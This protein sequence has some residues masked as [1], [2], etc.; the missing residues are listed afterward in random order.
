M[1][2][3][4]TLLQQAREALQKGNPQTALDLIAE[5]GAKDPANPEIWMAR[6]VCLRA[7]GDP[8]AALEAVE[9]VLN[10]DP[11]HFFA[12]ISKGALAEQLSGV[13][14]A[15]RIYRDALKIAPPDERLPPALRTQLDRARR[16]VAEDSER[17]AA[18]IA[19]RLGADGLRGAPERFRES[20]DIMLGRSRPFV[21]QPLYFHYP[22]LPAIPFYPR[23]MFPW[24]GDLEA[25]TDRVT[26]ELEGALRALA[27][28]FEPYIQYPEGAPVNQWAELNNSDRWNTLHLWRDGRAISDA[29][30]QCAQTTALLASL[31]IARQPGYA[32]TAMFSRLEPHTTI[33][34]HTGSSNV[35]L[36]VHLPLILPGPARFRVGN[37]TRAWVRGEAWVF[38]D[39]IEHEAWNDADFARVILIFDVWNPFLSESERALITELMLARRD[40]AAS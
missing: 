24:L 29:Q 25:A 5:A 2:A 26:G 28:A 36:I 6:A 15:A 10:L 38:D 4:P 34:P 18:F 32:P 19:D 14:P 31:P 22:Q 39:T 33:P 21:Q 11:V 30:A 23:E 9:R 17:L 16:I 27:D 13:K 40:Y 35:R 7:A 20:L 37:E 12:L 3:V 8:L 1:I